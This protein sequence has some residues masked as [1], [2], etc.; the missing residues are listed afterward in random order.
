MTCEFLDPIDIRL[1][2]G[3]VNRGNP[4]QPLKQVSDTMGSPSFI[5]VTCLE[6]GVA[7]VTLSAT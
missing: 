2:R 5:D 4:V 1:I 7:D 6:E 3:P